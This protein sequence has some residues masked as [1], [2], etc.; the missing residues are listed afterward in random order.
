MASTEWTREEKKTDLSV[1]GG[2]SLGERG[3]EGGDGDE[4]EAGAE[5]ADGRGASPSEG[6]GSCSLDIARTVRY[7]ASSLLCRL[8]R[9]CVSCVERCAMRRG[10]SGV[11]WRGHRLSSAPALA[12]GT[13]TAARRWINFSFY[14]ERSGDTIK[15]TAEPGKKVLDIAL[16]N[17]IDIEGKRIKRS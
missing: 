3:E 17:N 16:E 15:V 6:E 7:N 10:V 8:H 12:M 9:C 13:T 11:L 1:E 5:G 14:E 4:D 2:E